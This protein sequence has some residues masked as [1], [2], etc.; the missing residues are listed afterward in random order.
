M[1]KV[2]FK[3]SLAKD[4]QS[5]GLTMTIGAKNIGT[6]SLDAA[7]MDDLIFKLSRV[8]AALADEV[9][10]SLDPGSNPLAVQGPMR[11][12]LPVRFPTGYALDLRHPGYGWIRVVFPPEQAAQIAYYLRK[13]MPVV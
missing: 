1:Q 9:P 10:H 3:M 8:R 6:A 2:D 5:V 11:R 7:D 12:E 4:R 13:D